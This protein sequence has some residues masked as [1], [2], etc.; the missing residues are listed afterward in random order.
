MN[1]K[2]AKSKNVRLAVAVHAQKLNSSAA[3]GFSGGSQRSALPKLGYLMLVLPGAGAKLKNK[4]S[5]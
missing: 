2:K 4:C 1:S 5:N 3:V